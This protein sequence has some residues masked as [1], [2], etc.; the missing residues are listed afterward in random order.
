M[1]CRGQM[2]SIVMVSILYVAQ[3]LLFSVLV[4][5]PCIEFGDWGKVWELLPQGIFR[6]W[7]MR[8]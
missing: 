7:D 6:R 2:L 8:M 1:L 3:Q 4:L 5:L